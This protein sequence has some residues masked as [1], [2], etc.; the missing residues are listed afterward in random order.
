MK[1]EEAIVLS[2]DDLGLNDAWS[3]CEVLDKLIESSEILLHKLDYDGHGWEK[4]QHC[5]EKAKEYKTK[6]HKQHKL[7][8]PILSEAWNV[9]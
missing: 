2:K 7:L 8:A 3:L 1:I 9:V 4:I 6:L 5:K